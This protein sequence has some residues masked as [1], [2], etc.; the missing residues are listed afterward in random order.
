[1]KLFLKIKW[2]NCSV[3]NGN[4]LTYFQNWKRTLTG[5]DER[6]QKNVPE[7]SVEG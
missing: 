5:D 2:E 4:G 7:Q 1:M 6:A 3:E